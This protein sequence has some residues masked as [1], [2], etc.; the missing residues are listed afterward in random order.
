MASCLKVTYLKVTFKNYLPLFKLEQIASDLYV[1]NVFFKNMKLVYIES[2]FPEH[3]KMKLKEMFSGKNYKMQIENVK[4]YD[5]TDKV[6]TWLCFGA[7]C[8]KVPSDLI[9]GYEKHID[10]DNKPFIIIR[11]RKRIMVTQCKKMSGSLF[12]VPFR[13][14]ILLSKLIKKRFFTVF[15]E[16]TR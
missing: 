12:C 1:E 11:F 8:D 6:T 10:R 14:R 9:D 2:C 5:N 3:L 4:K 7:N 15:R 16:E 13:H